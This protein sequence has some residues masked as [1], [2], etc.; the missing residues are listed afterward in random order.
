VAKKKLSDR[1]RTLAVTLKVAHCDRAGGE[2][3]QWKDLMAAVHKA[4]RFSTALANWGVQQLFKRDTTNA[5]AT[6]EE[7]K[8]R[9]SANQKGAYLYGLA[10]KEFPNWEQE[11][12]GVSLSAV[13]VLQGVQR[14]YLSLRFKTLFLHESRLLTYEYPL[15]FP[16]HNQRW[17][18]SFDS[19]DRPVVTVTLPELGRVGLRLSCGPEHRYQRLR[20]RQLMDGSAKKGELAL[21]MSGKG[22]LVV[23]VVGDFPTVER[24]GAPNVMFLHTDPKALLVA[25]VNGHSVTVTNADH[26]QRAHAIITEHHRRHK[27]FLQRVAEDKKREVRMDRNQRRSL[28]N[29][30]AERCRKNDDKITTAVQ[31]IAAQVAKICDR[32]QV[33][34]IVYDDAVQDFLPEGFRWHELKTAIR[35]RFLREVQGEWIDGT[36]T[37]LNTEGDR[38]EWLQRIR[39]ELTAGRRADQHKRRKGS[40]PAVT[41]SA[42]DNLPKSHRANCKK[43]SPPLRRSTRS[44]K[45][46]TP[47]T[48]STASTP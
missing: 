30:I 16:I 12:V 5:S 6:P 33:G 14:K 19:S 18:L 26:L 24:E 34:L 31:Q 38:V 47:E 8:F 28:N 39:A 25:E 45:V 36:Y 20:L 15:P 44:G 10:V 13:S 43:S 37:H 32:K 17:S 9:S 35:N 27:V 40:H 1:H 22:K 23:K 46:G 21:M 48:R 41:S 29:R 4:F 3:V 7:V 42:T 2:S 11:S